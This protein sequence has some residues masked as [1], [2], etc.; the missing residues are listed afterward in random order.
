MTRLLIALLV[1]LESATSRATSKGDMSFAI[2]L[3][4]N[5]LPASERAAP[6]LLTLLA[7][8]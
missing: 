2:S 1:A 3:F 6:L 4:T 5:V 7:V 8:R